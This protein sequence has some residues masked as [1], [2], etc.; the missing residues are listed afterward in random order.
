MDSQTEMQSAHYDSNHVNFHLE[1][2]QDSACNQK[3]KPGVGK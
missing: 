3:L 2:K 1:K